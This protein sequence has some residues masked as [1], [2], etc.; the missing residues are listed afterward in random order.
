MSRKSAA[1]RAQSRA[2]RAERTAELLSL[3]AQLAL[4]YPG[5]VP[6]HLTKLC[7]VQTRNALESVRRGWAPST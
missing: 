7:H 2:L 1:R 5:P 6:K 3:R 4:E